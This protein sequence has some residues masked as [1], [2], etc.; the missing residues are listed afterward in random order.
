MADFRIGYC[1]CSEGSENYAYFVYDR[2]FTDNTR[3]GSCDWTIR[4]TC[5]AQYRTEKTAKK[6]LKEL[7]EKYGEQ[8]K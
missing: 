3:Y 6:K 4:N 5:Y 2:E 8:S 1:P 7:Q